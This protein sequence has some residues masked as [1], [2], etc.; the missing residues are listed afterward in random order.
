MFGHVEE[1]VLGIGG[2]LL[3][4][5]VVRGSLLDLVEEVLLDVELTNVRDGAAL[6]SVVGEKGSTVVNNS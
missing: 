6:D 4:I 5:D 1:R 2:H 3:G